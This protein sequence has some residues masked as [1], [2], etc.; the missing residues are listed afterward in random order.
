MCKPQVLKTISIL[1]PVLLCF[2]VFAAEVIVVTEANTETYTTPQ[3][4][5][6]CRLVVGSSV[7]GMASICVML[8]VVPAFYLLGIESQKQAA[9][10]VAVILLSTMLVCKM[11]TVTSLYGLECKEALM[12]ERQ[13]L[14]FKNGSGIIAL[15]IFAFASFFGLSGLAWMHLCL[16]ARRQEDHDIA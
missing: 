5:V 15:Q 3:I 6:S 14:I 7:A 16:V 4:K 2:G 9:Q 11:V 1:L 12:K 8:T 10:G 13:E